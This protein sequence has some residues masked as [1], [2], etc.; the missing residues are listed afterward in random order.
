[1]T[2]TRSNTPTRTLSV[3]HTHTATVTPTVIPTFTVT[4]TASSS[5]TRS[6]TFSV[7]PTSSFS[8]TFLPT[9]TPKVTPTRYGNQTKTPTA[10]PSRRNK[11]PTQT[12]TFSNTWSRTNSG[13]VSISSSRTRTAS[14]TATSTRSKSPSITQHMTLTQTASSTT[15]PTFTPS[16]TT[17]ASI[18]A[19]QSA[20]RSQSQTLT[21]SNSDSATPDGSATLSA[22]H[23]MTVIT[24]TQTPTPTST[25]SV[26]S[27]QTATHWNG[28]WTATASY[29]QEL[30]MTTS[31]SITRTT[32]VT[33][34]QTLTPPL[35]PTP[36]V[37]PTPSFVT[38]TDSQT[39]TM[40][41]TTT[42]QVHRQPTNTWTATDT[43][44]TALT[45][46]LTPTP[47][48]SPTPTSVTPTV[49]LTH[50]VS[51]THTFTHS[52]A[53]TPTLTVSPSETRSL[54]V[55]PRGG[56]NTETRTLSAS[57]TPTL[58][59]IY[60]VAASD[61][62]A[63]P[64]H[65]PTATY[66][67]TSVPTVT[68]VVGSQAGHGADQTSQRGT[69][70]HTNSTVVTIQD[71]HAME[72]RHVALICVTLAGLVTLITL[73]GVIWLG[74]ASNPKKWHTFGFNLA[75]GIWEIVRLITSIGVCA[76]QWQLQAGSLAK[77]VSILIL[78]ST[79]VT[80][81]A[82]G[83]WAMNHSRRLAFTCLP[84]ARILLLLWSAEKYAVG[85]FFHMWLNCILIF[86]EA[87]PNYILA[88]ILWWN[89]PVMG[90]ILAQIIVSGTTACLLVI[91]SAKFTRD[92]YRNVYKM[93]NTVEIV[94]HHPL[95]AFEP[96]V[97][98]GAL[99]AGMGIDEQQIQILSIRPDTEI[100]VHVGKTDDPFFVVPP[101]CL[102]SRNDVPCLGIFHVV[103]VRPTTTY[104]IGGDGTPEL[105]DNSDTVPLKQPA[106]LPPPSPTFPLANYTGPEPSAPPGLHIEGW[107][108]P[109]LAFPA[110]SKPPPNSPDYHSGPLEELDFF[111]TSARPLHVGSTVDLPVGVSGAAG[112]SSSSSAPTPWWQDFPDPVKQFELEVV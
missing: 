6:R 8:P 108:P 52:A 87:T 80:H 30:T 92:C 9:S 61:A 4:V 91:T 48:H 107:Q 7:T 104:I 73:L 17:S 47:V 37:S 38:P 79:V 96:S 35:T 63:S 20:S 66:T 85:Q 70:V 86:T 95:S 77:L 67:R 84:G 5:S 1:M 24:P 36:T 71:E 100:R 69:V 56:E 26:T 103:L 97:F 53:C 46:T 62:Q 109:E 50:V 106:E 59:A 21:V 105:M 13:T 12:G 83:W 2:R 98:I 90:W 33:T 81:L 58:T 72:G 28:T 78:S 34:H 89:R 55:Q 93:A 32:S 31:R 60:K 18:T 39:L 57:A 14:P 27:S 16:L 88:T 102:H 74:K 23:S 94:L 19:T 10:T 42:N 76:Q 112:P 101:I 15:S 75:V 111:P 65:T 45:S 49:T 11:T 43:H 68:R 64:T 40:T 82:I 25:P 41:P 54:T 29:T 110:V 51:Q 3:S 22:T 99:S 44:S